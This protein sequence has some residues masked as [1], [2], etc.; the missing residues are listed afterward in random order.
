MLSG[1]LE[2]PRRA[3]LVPRQ[4]LPT[5]HTMFEVHHPAFPQNAGCSRPQASAFKS[6]SWHLLRLYVS[7]CM[8]VCL[9]SFPGQV[10][11]E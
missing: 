2:I 5:L 9:L 1:L 11:T 6:K 4:L 10:S 3:F 7:V 8:F